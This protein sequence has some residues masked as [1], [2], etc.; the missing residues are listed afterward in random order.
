MQSMAMGIPAIVSNK[1]AHMT[2]C[3]ERN[4]LLVSANKEPIKN[5]NWLLKEKDQNGHC[6]YEPSLEETKKQMRWAV[7][8]RDKLKLI[9]K[10]AYT[11]VLPYNWD[12]TAKAFMSHMFRIQD[13]RRK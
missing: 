9:G 1:T 6:W 10:Q 13:K 12:N 4:T 11:D 8:N 7:D 5:I 3:N 2:F